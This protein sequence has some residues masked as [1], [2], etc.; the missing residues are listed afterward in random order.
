MG[1]EQGLNMNSYLSEKVVKHP[2]VSNPKSGTG[3]KDSFVN[4]YGIHHLHLG[5]K[6]ENGNTRR[7]NDLLFVKICDNEIYFIDIIDHKKGFTKVGYLLEILHKNFPQLTP[8]SY[9]FPPIEPKNDFEEKEK[10]SLSKMGISL[11]HT[12]GNSTFIYPITKSGHSLEEKRSAENFCNTIIKLK[13][14]MEENKEFYHNE[15]YKEKGIRYNTL[16]LK[17]IFINFPYLNPLC[18]IEKNS[19]LVLYKMS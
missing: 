13:K 7:T 6:K 12:I 17:A 14:F 18:I 19:S 9:P 2:T 4:A 5:R 11:F 1:F 3:D 15:I 8:F 16:E 10:L